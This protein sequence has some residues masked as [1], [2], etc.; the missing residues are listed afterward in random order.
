MAIF[1]IVKGSVVD[2]V[3]TAE[4]PIETD[5]LWIDVTD[6]DP[7]VATRWRYEDGKF[8]PPIELSN[9]AVV[10][11][12]NFLARF[13]DEE[14]AKFLSFAE[15]DM[16]IKHWFDQ[17]TATDKVD[18]S[19]RAPFALLVNKVVTKQRHDELFWSK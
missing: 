2:G 7:P 13:T 6:H 12:P 17:V 8:F 10:T 18:L 5:G 15:S 19:F 9:P 4:A 1:A 11:V 3:T 14:K 16:C